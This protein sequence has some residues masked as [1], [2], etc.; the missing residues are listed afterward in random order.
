MSTYINRYRKRITQTSLRTESN[1]VK[2]SNDNALD[3]FVPRNDG[4][5]N[6]FGFVPR[7]DGRRKGFRTLLLAALLLTGGI[8]Q[9]QVVIEGNVYGG[10]NLG[11]VKNPAANVYGNTTVTI[12]D[13]TVE[14]SVFGGGE[15]S[16]DDR[17][18]GLVEGN[19][20]VDMKGGT[21]ERSIYGGGSLGSVG[22]FTEYYTANT[23]DGHHFAGEPKVC[24]KKNTGVAKVLIS[25]GKVGI[26]G[27]LMPI[28]GA[29]PDDDDRGWIFCGSRGEADSI[30]YPKANILAFVDSTYLEISGTALITASVYGGSENGQV[31]RNTH[32]KITSGQ[33]GTGCSNN[34]T[35]QNG[36]LVGTFDGAYSEELWQKAM[37]SVIGGD[38]VKLN[39]VAAQFHECDHW[40][41]G[42]D[43][44]N[45]DDTP[46]VYYVYD[47]FADPELYPDYDSHGGATL[48]SSGH[49][50]FGNVF[51]GGSGYY[52]IAPGVWRRTAG[53]VLG[54]TTVDIT[55][56]HI[57]SN[58]YGGNEI[59]DVYGTCTINMSGG[60]LGVPR[61]LEKISENPVTCYLFGAGMGDSRD[62]FNTWTNVASTKVNISG[63]AFFFGSV[64]GGGE[65]GHVL[66]DAETTIEGNVHIGTWGYSSVDGNVFGGGRGFSGNALTDGAVVGNV[67]LNI[68]NGTILG[69]V[70]GGGRLS[71]IGS[72]LVASDDDNYGNLQSGSDHG[73][74]TINITGGTIG[75]DHESKLNHEINAHDQMHTKGGNVYGGSMGRIANLDNE[76]VN[77]LW[78]NLGKVKKTTVNISGNS[79]IIKGS[80]FGGGESGVVTGESGITN[81][82]EVKLSSGTIWRNVY[83]GGFGSDNTTMKAH[84]YVNTEETNPE[85]TPMQRAGL[86]E[87]NTKITIEGGWVKKSVYGGGALASTG[88]IADSTKHADETTSFALSWPY[89]MNYQANTG[90]NTVEITGGR[91]GITGKD[92]MGPWNE[93]GDPMVKINGNYVAYDDSDDEHKAA[94]KAARED[95]GDVFGAAKGLAGDR[96]VMAHMGNAS[97][98]VVTVNYTNTDADPTNY[99][100]SDWQSAFYPTAANWTTYG[101]RGCIAGSLYGG[102]ENG[103]VLNTAN[104]TLTKGLIGHALY[105]GGKGKDTYT[106]SLKNLGSDTEYH[107]AEIYSLTA[108][109][110]YGNTSVTVNA[111]NNTDAYVL[112]NIYGGGNMASVG[113]GNY[114]GGADDD[115]STAGY[116]EKV[117]YLWTGGEGTDAWHFRTSGKTTV[118]V[119]GGTVGT[120]S[121]TKD[122]LPTG[123]VFGG[124]RGEAAPN[125]LNSPRYEYA[126]AFFSGYVNK[127]DVT[128][129]R[130]AQGTEGEEGYVPASAPV[131]Y[132]SVYGGGQ[133]G[134][135][136]RSTNVTI[137][138]NIGL[139]YNEANISAVGTSDLTDAKWLYR[140]NVFGGGSGISQYEYDLPPYDGTI[141]PNHEF[142][143]TYNGRTI[144]LKEKDYSNS[145]GSVTDSTTV[146]I[147]SGTV[148]RNIYGGGSLATVGP[149]FIPGTINTD[150]E[151]GKP[152]HWSMNTVEVNNGTVGELDGVVAGY[153]GHV[154]GAGRGDATLDFEKFSTSVQ[155]S[156]T[157]GSTGKNALVH[158]NLYG[159]GEIGQ[160]TDDTEANVVS[161]G[162]VGTISYTKTDEEGDYDGITH[163]SGGSVFGGGKGLSDSDKLDA[164]RVKG[165]SNVNIS[166][167]KVYYNVYGGGEVASVGQHTDVHADPD[168]PESAVIDY[169]PK[170]NTGLASVTVTGGQVGPAPKVESGYSIPVGLNGLDGYV[171]GGGQGIG[172]DEVGNNPADENYPGQ[173]HKIANVNYTRVEVNITS[174]DTLNNRIWGSV[175]GG[176]EDGHVLG[177]DTVYYKSGYLGT[178]GM[179]NHDGNIFGGGRNHH[180]KNYTA[181]RTRGNTYM[182]MTGG[183]IFGNIYGGGRLAL[184]GC[185]LRG[186][187]VDNEGNFSPMLDGHDDFGNTK[188]LVK[189]GKVGNNKKTNAN[190]ED[191]DEMVIETFSEYSMG[192]VY[193]GGKGEEVGIDVTGHPKAS[194]LML[195]M[196]KNTEVEVS[197]THEGTRVYGI[198][199]GGGETANVGQYSWKVDGSTGQVHSINITEGL[200]KVTISGGTIGADRAKMRY[201]AGDAPYNMYPKYNDDLGY[202]YG[203]GEGISDDPNKLDE[204]DERVYPDI[205]ADGMDQPTISLLD[206]MATVNNTEVEITST[207]WVKAS[208]FGGGESGHVRGDTKVTISGGTVGAGNN[209]V[210]DRD[211]YYDDDDFNNPALNSLYGTTH[212]PYGATIGGNTVYHPYDPVYVMNGTNPS[213]G[214]S[215]FGNVFGGGS[216]WFPYI[217]GD[218]TTE[219]PYQSNWNANSGRVWGNTE[220]IITGGHIL[221]NVYGGNESTDVG[222]YGIADAAYHTAHP[223]VPEGAP[224]WKTGGTAT[225]T[226]S[227]GTIGVPRDADKVL[228]Q[229]TTGNLF[230]GG[231]GDPRRLFNIHTNVDTT[232]VRITGGTVYGAVYG[233][234]EMGHVL[235]GTSVNISQAEGKTTVIGSSGFSGYDGHVFGGGKGDET[236]YD[237]YPASGDD[238]PY[239][240]FACGR[241]GGNTKVTMSSGTVLGNLYGGGMIALTGVDAEGSF[242]S[243]ITGT[244]YDSIRHG[245][246][247]IDLSGGTIGNNAND[248]LDLLMSGSDLGNVYGG[249]RGNPEELVED[250]LGRVANAITSISGSPIILG[251][252]FGGGQMANV[253]HWRNYGTWYTTNTGTTKVTI[254]DSPTIGLEKEFDHAYSIGTGNLEP[255]WTWYDTING[256][257]MISHTCTGNVFGGGQGDVEIDDGTFISEGTVV[258]FEQGHCRTTL[259]EISGTPTIRSSV[260]GGGEDGV[261]WGDTRITISGGTIGTDSIHYDSL[262]YENNQWVVV[263]SNSTYSFGSVFGGSYGKD[264]YTHIEGVSNPTEDQLDSIN[265]LAGRVL[266]NTRVDITGGQVHGNVYGGGNMASVGYWNTLKNG[267]QLVDLVPAA[268]PDLTGPLAGKIMGNATVNISGSAVIGP[269]DETGLNAYVFGGGKGFHEDPAEL[270][271]AYCNVDSTFVTVS[272]GKVWGSVFGGGN[273]AHVLGST[274]VIVHEGADLGRDGLSTWDGNIFGGGRNFLN[275]NHSNGRVAGNVKIEMDGGTM[276]GS[277]FGGGRMALTGVNP[278]GAFPASDWDVTK[279]GNVTINVSGTATTSD[280]V[281]TYSTVIGNGSDQGIH[282]LTESDESVGD[283]FGSGKGDTKNYD[284]IQ[285]GCVTNAT[286]T[287]TGSPRIHG[288]VFGGGEMASLG[289][290]D[291]D[292]N[293]IDNT[294][295]SEITIGREGT[296]G[297]ND[298]P[299]IG[300][301]LELDPDYIS[302]NLTINGHDYEHSDWTIIETDDDGVKRVLHT[303]TGNVIGG[304]QGD[305]DFEDWVNNNS[306]TWN[307]WPYMA[308]SNSSIVTINRGTIM[309]HV[310]G[311]SEQGTVDG[312]AHVTINGGTIGYAATATNNT[313]YNFGGVF[314]AG[315]GSDDPDEDDH[316]IT[317]N[318][319]STT[320]KMVAGRLYG[321]TQVDVLGGTIQGDVFGGASFAYV[322]NGTTTGDA[323]T[324]IGNDSQYDQP[325]VGTTIKGRV[326]G[327]NNRAGT[328]YGN[329]DVNVYSTAHTTDNTHPEIPVGYTEEQILAWLATQPYADENFA[330]QAVYGGSNLADYTPVSGK[331]ATVH[332][333]ECEE[334]TIKDVYGGSNAADI[335]SITAGYKTNT[336]VIIDGGRI[337][338]VFGGGN[339]EE[340]PADIHGTAHTEVNGGLI[341]QVF[342]GSN[343]DGIID[344][345]ILNINQEGGCPLY[346]Q[347]IFGGGNE[348]LV[349]GDVVSTVECCNSTYVNY[350]GGTNLANIYGNVTVNIFGATFGNLFGGSK[351]Q[352]AAGSTPAKPANIK[353]FPS[354]TDEVLADPTQWPNTDTESEE[355]RVYQYLKDQY[356]AGN[357]L[358][359]HGGKVTLNI[360]G[361]TIGNAFGGS[362]EN[363]NIEGE[364]QVNVFNTGGTCDLDLTN[365]YG[366]GRNT[367][368]TPDY[369]LGTGETERLTPEINI[370]HGTV[371]GNVF[372][373]GMGETATTTASPKVNMGYY[374]DLG[375]YGHEGDLIDKLYDTIN[376]HTAS[377][378]APASYAAFVK[379]NMYGGGELAQ[380]DGNTYVFV[381]Q[382]VVGD[383]IGRIE[384]H[385]GADSTF[386][387]LYAY[388]LRGGRVFGG[389]E[390][391]DDNKDHGLV[392]GNTTVTMTGGQVLKN[393]YGGGELA[394]VGSGDLSDKTTGVAKVTIS[395]GEIG[396]LDGSGTNAYVFGGGRGMNDYGYEDYANVDSTS[397]V[398]SG[399]ARIFGSIFGGSEDGHVLGD[400]NISMSGGTIG[401]VGTTTWDGNIF[402]G[403]RNFEHTTST[404]GRVGGNITV[405]MTGGTLKGNLYGGGRNAMTGIDADGDMQDGESHGYVTVTVNGTATIGSAVNSETIGNVFGGGRGQYLDEYGWQIWNWEGLGMV[406]QT[407]TN[408]KNGRVYGSVYGGGEV[409]LVEQSTE[410]NIEGGEVGAATGAYG[411]VFGGGKGF[412]AISILEANPRAGQVGKSTQVNVKDGQVN[413]NV[414]GGGEVA[415]V[416]DYEYDIEDVYDDEHNFIGFSF[417][418][419]DVTDGDAHVT[420]S[421]GQ[422]GVEQ[423]GQAEMKGGTVYGGGLGMAGGKDHLPFGNVYSTDVKIK[424]NAYI[425]NAVFGGGDNGHVMQH[426]NITMTDGTVGKKNTLTEF[427]VDQDEQAVNTHIYTGSIMGGGRGTS[428]DASGQYNDTTGRVFG[429][430]YVT[431]SGG[432]VRHGVY[433]GG[434]LSSIGTYEIPHFMPVYTSGG[435]CHVTINGDAHIGPTKEDLTEPTDADL[436]AAKAYYGV[437]TFTAAQY[438]DTCF[439]YLGGNA[440]WVFGSGY[441]LAGSTYSHLTANKSTHLEVSGDAQVVGAVFGGG[442]SAHV[443]ENTN[444][445]VKG[446]AIVGGVPLHGTTYNIPTGNVYYTTTHPTL[447]LAVKDSET[448]E[449]DYGN[450]RYVYR[451][452]VYGGGKGTDYASPGVYSNSAGRVY[453]ST[454]V[455]IDGN[456]TIYNRVYGGGS[457]ASVGT[458]TYYK[459]LSSIP[460]DG[461]LL[462]DS[463]Q[464]ISYVS[465][466]GIANVTINGGTIGTDGNN[467]GDV[468]GGG[469]G[470]AGYPG[471]V[472]VIPATDDADQVV[473]LAYVGST[474]VTINTG[475]TVK[476]NVYGGSMNGHVYGNT[477]VLVDGGTVGYTYEEGGVTKV[478]GDWHG[479][480]YGGGG[481]TSHY[482]KGTKPAHLSITSG[483]VY[484]NTTVEVK[485][486]TVLNKVY[487]GG[488]IASV[489]TYDLRP[490]KYPV[491]PNT[492]TT[493]VFVTGG[494]I[495]Y[496]GNDNGDVY[497]SGRGLAAAPLAYVDSLTYAVETNVYIGETGETGPTVKGSV[498]GSGEN[499]HVFK[500]ANVNIITGTVEQS[501]FGA[502]SGNDT[503]KDASNIEHYNPIA[504]CVQ[505]NTEVTMTGGTVKENIYGGGRM[506]SVGVMLLEH[507]PTVAYPY[508]DTLVMI[509]GDDYGHTKITI[510]KGTVGGAYV[511]EPISAEHPRTGFVFGGSMGQ[512][513]DTVR[514]IRWEKLS[515]VKATNVTVKGTALVKSS[516]YGG[517]DMGRVLG[518]TVVNIQETAV[519]GEASETMAFHRGNVFGGGS[520]LDSLVYVGQGHNG[521][522]SIVFLRK[523]GQVTGTATVNMSGGT[524]YGN[525]YGGCE[526]TDVLGDASIVKTGGQV[527]WERT[528]DE[529]KARPRYGYVYGS[530]KGDARTRF[531]TWTNVANSHV[532]ITDG[533]DDR[534]YGCVFG[535]GEEGHVLGDAN[536]VV[537]SGT[538]GTFGYTGAEGNVFGGG[539]GSNPVAL[540]A[541]GV[542][543][544]THVDIHDG[545]MLGSIF[546]GGNNGSVGIYFTS[547]SSPNYGQMQDGTDHGYT[548][549][550]IDGG[551][552]GHHTD[553]PFR[554]TGGNVYGGSRG[555][556]GDPTSVVVNMAKVKETHVNISQASGKQTFIMGS[557]FGSGEDGHVLEDTYVTVSDGQIGGESYNPSSPT[558]CGDIYHGNVYGG[559]RGLDTYTGDDGQ[560]HFSLTAGKVYGNTNV[561]I[562]GGRVCRN[563]YG[564]GSYSSVGDP[565]EVPDG[566]GHYSTGLATVTIE[567]NA[568]IGV[569][570]GNTGAS[571]QENGHVF[572]SSRGG[573]GSLYQDLGFVKNTHVTIQ[574]N[575]NVYGSMFGSGEDGHVRHDTKVEVK[576]GTIGTA[577][578]SSTYVGNVYG[579]GRGVDTQTVQPIDPD[580]GEPAVDE[581]GDPIYVQQHSPTAGKVN[582]NTEVIVSAGQVLR[583]VYGGGNIASVG[584]YTDDGNGNITE[585]GGLA[586]VTV[587]GTAQVNGNVF[588]SGHGGVSH[589]DYSSEYTQLAYVK[590][591]DVTVSGTA[592]VNGSVFGGGEDGHVRHNTLVKVQGGTIGTSSDTNPLNGNVY[593]GGRGLVTEGETVSGTAGRVE[594]YSIVNISEADPSEPTT[595]WNNVYGGGS[596]SRV[597]VYKEVNV[598]GGTVKQNVFG[599]SREIPSERENFAP[600]W[601]NMWGGTVE[602]NLYGCSHSSTDGDPANDQDFASFINLSGGTVGKVTNGTV[603]GGNVYGAGDSGTVKGSVAILIGKNAID[604]AP[605]S[606]NTH[607]PATVT[608]GKLDIKGSVFAG[609]QQSTGL[610]WGAPAVTGSSNIYIDGDGYNTTSDD[611]TTDNYMHIGGGIY[612]SGASCEAGATSHD[613]LVRNYGTRTPTGDA[614]MTAATRTLT[615]I[616]RGGQVL[617]DGVNVKLSGATDISSTTDPTNYG[618]LNIDESLMVANATGIVLGTS[619]IAADGEN[620]AVPGQSVYMDSIHQ[621]RS[622]HLKSGTAYASPVW[623]W[624]GITGGTPEGASLMYSETGTSLT[625]ANENVILFKD[626]SQ[627]HVRYTEG[628]TTKYGE[629]QGFFRMKSDAFGPYGTESF[630]YARPKI[631]DGSSTPDNG[632]DGGFLSYETAYNFHTDNGADY[633]KT[634]QHPYVNVLFDKGD[635][636]EYR[637]WA[638]PSRN[639]MRWYVDGR[640][641]TTE[642]GWGS[643]AV[644]KINGAGRYPDKPKKTLFGA[645]SGSNLGGVITE[646]LTSVDEQKFNYLYSKDQIY[647]VG[648]LSAADEAH[649]IDSIGPDYKHTQLRLYRYPGGHVMSNGERDYGTGTTPVWGVA[650]NSHDGPGANYGAMLNVQPNQSL[651]LRGVVIDGLYDFTTTGEDPDVTV[652]DIPTADHNPE[653]PAFA[654]TS[655]TKPLIITGSNSTLTLNDSIELMR[656]Y[657]NTDAAN[658]WY[659][660]ADYTTP[661]GTYHGG[662]L[663]VDAGA[664]VNVN[665]LVKITGNLQK[666]GSGTVNSNVYLPTFAKSLTI[667]D[668][669][670]AT[671]RIGVTSPIRNN[672]A[673]YRYNTFSPVAVGV[674][675]GHDALSGMAWDT[676]DARNAWTNGNFRDDLGWFFVNDNY[677]EHLRHSYYAESIADYPSDAGFDPA[678]TLFFGWT[679][680]NVVRTAPSG[681]DLND[682]NSA[683]DMAWLISK[684]AG[685]NGE[686]VTNFGSQPLSQT[687]D[688]D[689]LKYVWV[690][691]GEGTTE[692]PVFAGTF[693][694]RGHL[695]ENLYVK[696]IGKHDARYKREH[697][698]MF[699]A[700]SGGTIDRTFV[701]SGEVSPADKA[702]TIGGLVGSL[703]GTVQYSEAAASLKANSNEY[704][705]TLG[706]LVGKLSSGEV[707]SS[708]AMTQ[709][710]ASGIIDIT[711]PESP[712]VGGL[713]GVVET[714]TKVKNSFAKVNGIKVSSY[715]D[716]TNPSFDHFVPLFGGLVGQNKGTVENNYVVY[717]NSFTNHNL[718][719]TNFGMVVGKNEGSLDYCYFPPKT[720]T[721]YDSIPSGGG[722]IGTNCHSYTPVASS[723]TYGYMHLDNSIKYTGNHLTDT[724][725]F[726]RLNQYLASDASHKYARWARPALSGINGDLP[727][728]LLENYN[729]S[730]KEGAGG[731]RSMTTYNGG[732]ALQYHG[733]VRDGEGSK[734]DNEIDAAIS[735]MTATDNELFVY[736]DI[737]VAPTATVPSAATNA[738]ISFH[739][740]VALLNAGTLASFTNN[741]VGIT[742]DNSSRHAHDFY[743][744]RLGRDWHMMSTP[745]KDAPL[746]IDYDGENTASGPI[747][748]YLQ[749]PK[750]YAFTS[751]SASG[752][753]GYFPSQTTGYTKPEDEPYAYPYDYYCWY[754]PDWQWINFK[755]NGPSHWHQDDY[756]GHAHIP[757]NPGSYQLEGGTVINGTPNVNETKLLPGKGYMMAIQDN[758]FMQSHGQL[759]QGWVKINITNQADGTWTTWGGKGNNLIGNPYH[760]YLDFDLFAKSD[761]SKSWNSP[762]N[763]KIYGNNYYVYDAD[764]N[765]YITYPAGGSKGGDYAPRYLHPHQGFI[766]LT[767]QY[768]DELTF[769]EDMLK[770]RE[771]GASGFRDE[772]QPAYPLVNLYADDANGNS[773]VLVVEFERPENGGGRK[774]MSLRNGNHLLYAHHE[775]ENYSAFFAVKGTKQVPVRFKT[776]DTEGVYTMRWNIQNGTFASIYLIDNIAGVKYDMN[777][778]QS[779]VFEASKTDYLSRFLIVFN[780]TDVEELPDEHHPF[781]FFDGTEWVV[782]G[783]GILQLIDVTGR[784]L[785]DREV[786]GDQTRISLKGYAKGVYLLRLIEKDT[787]KTQKL[788]WK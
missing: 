3:C 770:T 392:T 580:T 721:T 354:P 493:E 725:M 205:Y 615:T 617:L 327:A 597:L 92:F 262:K 73:H 90:Q 584:I 531:N 400:A 640:D 343:N 212:W 187:T 261:V 465:G 783:N 204:D 761:D 274:S 638:I 416:G 563:V 77:P 395:G 139:A 697:Y 716:A 335:G 564:G 29:N 613:I 432:T 239:P 265:G 75:N 235:R 445:E 513:I 291:A 710:D 33:I 320:A 486:G 425:T 687:A 411:D 316:P 271:K 199:F 214:R 760:A 399:N 464:R 723:D 146:V 113:K 583:N 509:D 85:V 438:A 23:A 728:L 247:E 156:A 573:A 191:V 333:Y 298:N 278:N 763:G 288:S 142:T 4:R 48:G 337:Y 475:A 280:D 53:R 781:A 35:M 19:T 554:R 151:L 294:G 188:V 734:V 490:N 622:L 201:E 545:T 528:V 150:D 730:N 66:G 632:S 28:E 455:T 232:D 328:P 268:Y 767:E 428:T 747:Y 629:L 25:G 164:A 99:V 778:H 245:K 635:R 385:L 182:E 524:V 396:P 502:G 771:V 223:E 131:I 735:A 304:C 764:K 630:A 666:N 144:T 643:D 386:Y 754:E 325:T 165:N 97:N 633:T 555:T 71:S 481:G 180:H 398:I 575:A 518:N 118:T 780:Y 657:N 703:S 624:I 585:S 12:N 626:A 103:H 460:E 637:L 517:S 108:G 776:F 172:D 654:P 220:V 303:C 649:L 94:L 530:G 562:T 43:H 256:M 373:G 544:N 682:I 676:I 469:R 731:F 87:G 193:G 565:D 311:G 603:S 548:Y 785:Y 601:L 434:G 78:P 374:S 161:G 229:P 742:F 210:A 646:V 251:S 16:T 319:T 498:Y 308:R 391:S 694:G 774:S 692:T 756:G 64:F 8:A 285:A 708:M 202:V 254:T 684:S 22:T 403:G 609:S 663:F 621:V 206:L 339:G 228:E 489:G 501:V 440:G 81:A 715:F 634:N 359:G 163:T 759:N 408:I 439:K 547:P 537:N 20:L 305:V 508:P 133:D 607:K 639:G 174:T 362:D 361:G 336:N 377:W 234:A 766:I 371:K 600:R 38:P 197:G 675:T 546:G 516:V 324:N 577:G 83:G 179:T 722:S 589:D 705:T 273:D 128:I 352:A 37:D 101:T 96:Y 541:G 410:V 591:T 430:T 463:I 207:A 608:M 98:A 446:N 11:Q 342:G 2:Q 124:C 379:G 729:A 344:E 431:I 525:L 535:G 13:G 137:N 418:I 130:L 471:N 768:S 10:C 749:S 287:I 129:G 674:R 27:S 149:P 689:L 341:N 618:V 177:S 34:T 183:Q 140:G 592:Q 452:N 598:S 40:P 62:M 558:L 521:A 122:G 168:D 551:T 777:R 534:I 595:I 514:P 209:T 169:A 382:G 604:N 719:T 136:R 579:G 670:D 540:T 213:D 669:L 520:G 39:G 454:N 30:T 456:A 383:S 55:G 405:E 664:T 568:K 470:L 132:G 409:A 538:I 696:Y 612:G 567:G 671:S 559:G 364:I 105:G 523:V 623:E 645:V 681:F 394:S 680:A 253:G 317:V 550:N 468:V 420:I 505:G 647:V 752:G 17:D 619:P 135:V 215:W 628:T 738:K 659:T 480:V 181:G 424:D 224:Y 642:G 95:N 102:G 331:Q 599:G 506:A 242:E 443:I 769:N 397:V 451:G 334:N 7:N 500:K 190:P 9:A 772:E 14:G 369:A 740:D 266:G 84:L 779:Y 125:I 5:R 88:I 414:F 758:T 350:Y 91:I 290:W 153:G 292:N 733:P 175:F 775:N 170:A 332:V 250:D 704:P 421:G 652:H 353:R 158:G 49:S 786:A 230:G 450:G 699:G 110:V 65:D 393:V 616:Q 700:V 126:P 323:L 751:A 189:G 313:P 743:G 185:G 757:Y 476:S 258:G 74:I 123:N 255:K 677:E 269:L 76:T 690:P 148:Y 406:K 176:S 441:G 510:S 701:V 499:G 709:I 444:V 519:I 381:Q 741:Y 243:Y 267:N 50:F 557:V 152:S 688:V 208:V 665:G 691:L 63:D 512:M 32:V 263:H 488:P 349:L 718:S 717:S 593:G 522:D 314:G 737:N 457:I 221:N 429:N 433:G 45:D 683:E 693:D 116:G 644:S 198:V 435:E 614:E 1:G 390:G 611:P 631:T 36:V 389:G 159:G 233:G 610:T 277:I 496:D 366:A 270:R 507:T 67:I 404:A 100:P 302:D 380:V 68:K 44:D 668:A 186:L 111:A 241:V 173:Y 112:R 248:G 707:H 581:N 402:G 636:T 412:V 587:S 491:A 714:D 72:H 586:E 625:K 104:V 556:P 497:G 192:N 713:V 200:A 299:V 515:N 160:V 487:G 686:T 321:N 419:T 275:S 588:G 89:E 571:E 511:N 167:G 363:G 736:G 368:Y 178:N 216:G 318:G 264:V 93:S 306:A 503:Y 569:N 560:Q 240:N 217:T 307:N 724:A 26:D 787:T 712:H 141:D 605:V 482:K 238:D 41:Y 641:N 360:F 119:T 477:N 6:A 552:I 662:A 732:S 745:L 746:G 375:V 184:T 461:I 748:Y 309:G 655:V 478:H 651:E 24:N 578:S 282:L 572:G 154:F 711:T 384:N 602:G 574:G 620:P 312:N 310:F 114:A 120:A 18:H 370:I 376:V 401:T 720:S 467:N 171:F 750:R 698:G 532:T 504:G 447:T 194:A 483:R 413:A 658:T 162:T 462:T 529:I 286:I 539:R 582:G 372:G 107:D 47:Y 427:L 121:G 367:A 15:G 727:V 138:G 296:A 157:V 195:G 449:D 667:T 225:V 211:E 590:N 284:D 356:T 82:T 485:S 58:I 459:E 46:D 61:T 706:G 679:W 526:V 155:T 606:D 166:G 648:A 773:E 60:T 492:G 660:N 340:Q 295:K 466:T 543:G 365:L 474:N 627:L 56:G 338:R 549:V 423:D 472:H 357:D 297:A 147:N 289:W 69:N 281:T 42:I 134:H 52:P 260:F 143:Y 695:I 782:N 329:V 527:G 650:A 561:S 117:A 196:T 358:R 322:G 494:T 672:E 347:D 252:V 276:Q 378:T 553:D 315:Y 326:F 744:I 453:G 387:G 576:G 272:G 86:V 283:I 426:A 259:V 219:H 436:A 661:S 388:Q 218:G 127:T 59:T 355:Y 54:N 484:G 70:Y 570:G 279:H 257:K 726:V 417:N 788:V 685:M 345:I 244:E 145:S 407:Q 115:Y 80:V 596:Q 300:T 702:E 479:N 293:F 739:E 226:M 784:V 458:F 678:K 473:R 21:V 330:I 222:D 79:T 246:T 765:N 415:S 231:A 437:E 346:I 673:S 31:L 51:G 753:D 542:G 57:L 236:D 448:A 653:C 106:V 656:G 594:G 762:N 351:G 533:S 442:E 109:K 348:A 301:Y 755:R 203:G 249:G 536:V 237:P 422:V 227:G 495:G 566:S